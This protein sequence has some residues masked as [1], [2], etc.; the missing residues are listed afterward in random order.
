M[1]PGATPTRSSN[2]PRHSAPS[3][4][5]SNGL[6]ARVIRRSPGGGARERAGGRGLKTRGFLVDFNPSPIKLCYRCGS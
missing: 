5:A 4:G 2:D 6:N 3:R 1:T